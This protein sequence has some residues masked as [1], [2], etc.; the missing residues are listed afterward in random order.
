MMHPTIKSYITSL[1]IYRGNWLSPQFPWPISFS[2]KPSPDNCSQFHRL[3]GTLL[4]DLPSEKNNASIEGFRVV[5]RQLPQ[6]SFNLLN[7]IEEDKE[8]LPFW[9]KTIIKSGLFVRFLFLSRYF[10]QSGW[11][12]ESG[13][14]TLIQVFVKLLLTINTTPADVISKVNLHW[15]RRWCEDPRL[16]SIIM[17]MSRLN[18]GSV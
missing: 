3:Y 7:A 15:V 12:F 11:S 5:I 10:K 9:L 1:V 4:T 8:K 6:N 17:V 13:T 16:Y 18:K 14:V 2:G